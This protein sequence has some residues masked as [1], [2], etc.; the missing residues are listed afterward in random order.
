M[1][2]KRTVKK[3]T[4]KADKKDD[5]DKKK[6]RVAALAGLITYNEVLLENH[7]DLV[8][9]YKELKA[10]F[11]SQ[12]NFSLCIEKE[13]R[14]HVHVF[15]ESESVIDCD[16]AYFETTKSGKPSDF[17]PNRGKNVARGHWY[18]QT[19]WKKSHITSY[20]DTLV[21]PA[22]KWL[23]DEW[24]NNKIETITEALAAEK[25][26]KPQLQQ[27]IS[28]VQ[29]H[30]E[31]AVIEKQ[32]KERDTRIK[33][34]LKEFAPIKAVVD[35]KLTFTVE[36][37]RYKFLVL[38]GASKLRKTEY[39]KSLFQNPFIHKDKVVWDG[40]KYLE[41]GCII[42][43]DINLPDHIWKYV[44]TNRVMFQMSSI[45]SVNTSATNCYAKNVCVVQKP[46]I[47]CTNDG[48]LDNFV[49]AQYRE[50]IEANS[51][52]LDV[53]EPIPFS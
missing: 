5:K 4:K 37:M 42:F 45:V 10:K 3:T 9:M 23:M 24:R 15:Y 48:L 6:F 19:K 44:R 11:S 21:K 33:Q 12:I 18:V 22:E 46:I 36:Q 29:N 51:V 28:A 49:S 47:I 13:S 52:W 8:E 34:E 50:W 38:C 41:H 39:A 53:S 2:K 40:Y 1:A 30:N 35:W 20:F 17:K 16:L 7:E 43:D 32:L 27:Q 14:L 31:L 25:L 26:L